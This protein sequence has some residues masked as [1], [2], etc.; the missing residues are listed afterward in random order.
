M[1]TAD[2]GHMGATGRVAST[3][4]EGTAGH[5]QQKKGG[6]ERRSIASNGEARRGAHRRSGL[7][8]IATAGDG[9]HRS[10]G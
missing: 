8:C 2:E 1:A 7:G 6:V 5:K 4:E 9:A 3:M 10:S